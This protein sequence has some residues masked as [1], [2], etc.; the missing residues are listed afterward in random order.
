[1]DGLYTNRS[2]NRDFAYNAFAR[3]GQ[4]CD[5]LIASAF[6]SS[7]DTIIGLLERGCQVQLI[8][9]LAAA[10]SP[11]ELKNI[12]RKPGVQIRYFTDQS[13]HPKLYIFGAACA[14]VGSANLTP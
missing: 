7:A 13:F 11:S 8:V 5:V 14:L 12:L 9:R 6:F 2:T 4:S 1:M 3:Y 10:T